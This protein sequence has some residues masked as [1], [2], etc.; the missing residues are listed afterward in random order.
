MPAGFSGE[1]GGLLIPFR[2]WRR[3]LANR[4]DQPKRWPPIASYTDASTTLVA[5]GDAG[6]PSAAQL[7]AALGPRAAAVLYPAHLEGAAGA[8]SLAETLEV[9]HRR[10][11][12][13]LVDAAG[14]V[15]PLKRFTGYARAGADL[16]CFGTK[17][18]GA[19][20]SS[21]ILCGRRDLVAAA[22]RQGFIGFETASRGKAFGRPFKLHSS[23]ISMKGPKAG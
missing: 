6:G 16:A 7:A 20:Q 11:V 23:A 15:Y 4:R 5:A 1:A 22:A 3:R 21:G 10:G 2:A 18:L 9:A 12:P 19:P 17:Y 13:V 14:Q 8:L